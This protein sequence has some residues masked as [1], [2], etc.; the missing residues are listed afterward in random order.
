MPK[1]RPRGATAPIAKISTRQTPGRTNLSLVLD[2]LSSIVLFVDCWSNITK[3]NKTAEEWFSMRAKGNVVGKS[4][5]EVADC[6]DNP[7][8][9][10][11]EI[12]QVA[13]SGF[14]LL[15][16]IESSFEHGCQHWYKVDKI[17]NTDS[18]G[19]VNGVIL[20]ANNISQ[21]VE[22][23]RVLR[24]TE[25]RYK[26][27]VANSADAIWRYDLMPAIPVCLPKEEQVKQIIRRAALMECNDKV[28]ELFQI[29]ESDDIIG[30]PLL[31]IRS[32]IDKQDVFAF[33]ENR[34]RLLHCEAEFV[35]KDGQKILLETSAVG[36]VKDGCLVR[37]WGTSRDV[38]EQKRNLE[39]ME[40]LAKHDALTTLPNRSLLYHHMER[41]LAEKEDDQKCALLLL[42]LDGFKEINDTLGHMV[43]DQVLKMMGPRFESELG[44][45]PGIVARLGGD[46][47]AIFIDDVR[48]CHHAIVMAHRFLDSVC[49]V[50]ELDGFRTEIGASIGVSICPDQAHD[51]ET[52]MRYADIAMYHAKTEL[53]GVAVYEANIDSHSPF[54]LELM[55]A[56]GRAIRENQL[57]LYFQPK[58]NVN[59]H[60]VYGFEGLLRW[61]HPELGFIPPGEFIPIAENSN[62]IFPLT[63]WVLEESAKQCAYCRDKGHDI[64]IAMN[65]SARILLDDRIVSE[66]QRVLR[67]YN[68]DGKFLEFEITESTIMSDPVRAQAALERISELGVHLSVDDFGTGYSSLAYLKRLPVQSLK[69]DCTF[70]KN[71][72][73]DEQD[74][75]IVNST[76]QLAHNLGLKVV[77]EGVE[78]AE[79]YARLQVLGCDSI[80]GYYVARP[81]CEEKVEPWLLQDRWASKRI[82]TSDE[83]V[84]G[85]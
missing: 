72:L 77:A 23:E 14:A 41:V 36:E 29:N 48:N 30:S 75:I 61:E 6:W 8:E 35:R 52:L 84:M 12:M 69:I 50:F 81:M 57:R 67:T 43:G 49:Q 27:F 74:E 66:L 46:E 42:D 15:D 20:I 34:Y 62:V 39:Q 13:R 32:I 31:T 18:E 76:I 19:N 17:P 71:M 16:S 56:L 64:T 11:R 58:V 79:T 7:F 78:N 45:I 73:E 10:R 9:R 85:Y 53:K 22:Q 3:A 5:V 54:R 38:S 80:Q 28:L 65:L 47:F 26:A 1:Q 70:V 82:R 51:V 44:A 21:Q 60:E 24:E 55:G 37:F 25:A 63:V 83:K 40:Y 68:L 59:H 2:S 4:F 33:V